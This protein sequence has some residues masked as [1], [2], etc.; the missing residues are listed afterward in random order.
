MRRLILSAC[1]LQALLAV[2]A[3]AQ[4]YGGRGDR[5][6]GRY[7]NRGY[8]RGDGRDPLDRV[9]RDLDR[10]ASGMRY[11][12]RGE[13]KRINHALDE[14]REFQ[15]KWAR[16]RFDKGELNDVI[17]GLQHVVDKNRL[18][19]RDRDILLNDLGQLREF[20]SGYSGYRDRRNDRYE[21]G[22]DQYGNRR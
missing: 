19:F 13:A 14:I 6:D 5:Y 1:L 15:Q 12:S 7:E 8:G 10:A 3:S 4:V 20:R 2:T 9:V 11:L 18:E 17:S 21:S 22:Y 16:G